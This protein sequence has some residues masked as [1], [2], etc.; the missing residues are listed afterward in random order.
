MKKV[1]LIVF[2]VLVSFSLTGC[3]KASEDKNNLKVAIALLGAKTD[4]GFNQVDY[5]GVKMAEA[6]LDAEISY[7][8]N[9]K[10]SDFD[11]V[12][13]TFAKNGNDVV[14]G[15]GFEFSDA[16]LKV[17]KDFPNTIFLVTDTNLTNDVNVGSFGT[18]NVETGFLDGAFAALMTKSNKVGAIGGMQIPAI[19]KS[20]EGFKAGAKYVKPDINVITSYVGDFVDANKAKE[21]ALTMIE[22]GTDYLMVNA[23]AAGS[24]VNVAAETKGIYSIGT[25]KPE[26]DT[27]P[28]SLIACSTVDFSTAILKAIEEIKNGT[29]KIG[30]QSF[31]LKEGINAFVYNTKLDSKVSNDVKNKMDDIQKKLISGEI[32]LSNIAK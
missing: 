5:E 29:F 22:Q 25:V 31:G 24:G 27:Y 21:M 4:G 13:R 28:N 6:Q 12:I 26:F 7:S 14:I 11:R 23:D 10:P 19:V 8:E 30:Y 16:I 3:N 15:H 17:A 1:L 32:D 18:N 20:L 2:A 9:T